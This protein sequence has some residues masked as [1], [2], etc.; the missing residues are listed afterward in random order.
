[1]EWTG[2]SLGIPKTSLRRPLGSHNHSHKTPLRLRMDL[3]PQ[4]PKST[5]I[6]GVGGAEF[7][8]GIG[9]CLLEAA[10]KGPKIRGMHLK[11]GAVQCNPMIYQPQ[12]AKNHPDWTHLDPP[13]KTAKTTVNADRSLLG[14]PDQLLPPK[15]VPVEFYVTVRSF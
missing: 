7:G 4:N 13:Q 11:N 6:R 3:L 14:L 8:L 2:G 15:L 5:I 9:R 12:G 10:G 1:M